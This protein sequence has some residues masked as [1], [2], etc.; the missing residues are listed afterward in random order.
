MARDLCRRLMRVRRAAHARLDEAE[1][2]DRSN[3]PHHR[4]PP[5][6]E[7][8]AGSPSLYACAQPAMAR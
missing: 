4:A 8:N 7:S 5:A 2:R 1:E 3:R 6:G